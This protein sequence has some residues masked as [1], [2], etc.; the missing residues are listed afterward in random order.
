MD[1]LL[2]TK[3]IYFLLTGL[4]GFLTALIVNFINPLASL[5]L[6]NLRF[7]HNFYRRCTIFIFYFWTIKVP[8]SSINENS[9]LGVN[10]G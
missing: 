2:K 3:A 8:K 9:V 6:H 5:A 1:K 7:L 4:M 10:E